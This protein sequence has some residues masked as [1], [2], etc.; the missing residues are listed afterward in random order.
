MRSREPQKYGL[1]SASGDTLLRDLLDVLAV[2][3]F[4]QI[5]RR[6]SSL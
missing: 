5:Q 4:D 2:N 6:T 1:H 3:E